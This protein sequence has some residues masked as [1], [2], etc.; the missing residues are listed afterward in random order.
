MT[1]LEQLKETFARNLAAVY[2]DDPTYYQ[3][4]R[5][6]LPVVV[7]RM[8]AA[9]DAKNGLRGINIDSRTFRRTAK[10][11]GIKNTYKAWAEWIGSAENDH[12]FDPSEFGARPK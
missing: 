4:P 9:M 10:E 5:S 11:L 2:D 6:E 3:W 8:H 7:H 1:R 12:L